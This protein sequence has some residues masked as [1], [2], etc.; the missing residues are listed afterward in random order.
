MASKLK[1]ASPPTEEIEQINFVRWLDLVGLTYSAVPSST[2]TTS[3]SVKNRNTRMG[4][5]PG[6]P[7]L[8]VAVPDI[9]LLFVELKRRK[10]GIVSEHQAKWIQIL[11]TIP[12]VEA[13]IC[14]GCDEAIS[15][16]TEFLPKDKRITTTQDFEIF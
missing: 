15:F 16:V 3:W 4:V 13:R 12:G 10:G 6:V 11:N 1:L 7:D 5:R 14:K 2:Y 8:I 9:G